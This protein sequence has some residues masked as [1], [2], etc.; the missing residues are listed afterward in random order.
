MTSEF[1][2]KNLFTPLLFSLLFHL[3]GLKVLEF[4]PKNFLNQTRV[5]SLPLNRPIK[6]RSIS[7]KNLEKYRTVGIKNGKKN[8]SMPSKVASPRL[9]KEKQVPKAINIKTTKRRKI[10]KKKTI[11]EKS[12]SLNSLRVKNNSSS[13]VKVLNPKMKR[14]E[15]KEAKNSKL[16]ITKKNTLNYQRTKEVQN[17]V[18]KQLASAPSNATILRK[19]GFNMQ[20]EPPEGVSE[21][22]LNSMEKI[23]YSFQKRT[24]RAYVGSF[25]KTY[26]QT[27][28]EHPAIK[29][30]LK[31]DTHRL[32]ARVLFDSKGNIISIKIMRSSSD[33]NVHNLF[34]ETL[35]EIRKLPNP[36]KDLIQED[37]QFIIYY[38][39]K[40]N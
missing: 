22:E 15:A 32:A 7:R 5:S 33:D 6:I 13:I 21:D 27:L 39:L 14:L 37:G 11:T 31:N 17:S 28:I 2:Q 19:T 1:N 30:S 9:I 4:L 40:I 18:L 16:T 3:A 26:K 38:Q 12:L 35:K 24:F 25:L 34:E 29:E 8:F 36:P 23:F 20:L 10:M